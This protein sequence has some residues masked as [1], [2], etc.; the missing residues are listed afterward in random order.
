MNSPTLRRGMSRTSIQSHTP[1]CRHQKSSLKI[2]VQSEIF[3]RF[4]CPGE[5]LPLDF[6][7]IYC[8]LTR[9]LR[10]HVRTVYHFHT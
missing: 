2:E 10:R 4:E 8:L 6:P 5:T 1:A 9:F 3:L 7:Q